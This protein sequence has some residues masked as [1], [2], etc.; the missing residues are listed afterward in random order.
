[1]PSKDFEEESLLGHPHETPSLAQA[2]RNFINPKGKPEHILQWLWRPII[3]HISVIL[4]YTLVFF[5][6]SSIVRK[7]CLA[8]DNVI[9]CQ[10]I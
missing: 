2:E 9:F 6:V 4:L 10:Y 3:L 7:D 1:M 8:E 5:Y